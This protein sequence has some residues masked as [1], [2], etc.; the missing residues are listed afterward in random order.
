MAQ[1]LLRVLNLPCDPELLCFGTSSQGFV[2]EEQEFEDTQMTKS[3]AFSSA[4]ESQNRPSK[5]P[6]TARYDLG[7]A[8][9]AYAVSLQALLRSQ[10]PRPALLLFS[11]SSPAAP[12]GTA[13]HCFL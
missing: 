12:A 1:A 9:F 6:K 2:Q 3:R 10:R 8:A 11:A 5:A 13:P 4:A 7:D